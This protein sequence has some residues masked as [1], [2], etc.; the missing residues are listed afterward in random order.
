[1]AEKTVNTQ[2]WEEEVLQ[3]EVPVMVDFGA[4]WCM[5]CR[6]IAPMIEE[7]AKEYEGKIKVGKLNIDDNQS[8]AQ[9]YNIMGVPTLLFFK[10]GQVVDRVVGVAAKKN[11]EN[12]IK[13]ITGNHAE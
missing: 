4:E 6:M 12:K 13:N 1:M 11:I 3:S 9:K 8:L 2:N 5:P 10:Q 7:I